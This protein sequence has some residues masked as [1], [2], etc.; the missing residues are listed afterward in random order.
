MA[1]VMAKGSIWEN[2]KSPY[3]LFMLLECKNKQE[4]PAKKDTALQLAG[5]FTINLGY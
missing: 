4:L 2:H 5:M 3:T 1:D